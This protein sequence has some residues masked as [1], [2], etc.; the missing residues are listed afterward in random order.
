MK[1]F[2]LLFAVIALAMMSCATDDMNYHMQRYTLNFE[3]A[4]WD[5]LVDSSVNGDNLLGGAI[6]RVWHDDKSD[7]VG[8]I[9]EPYTGY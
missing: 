6:A 3:G 4:Y 2:K 7:L 1:N 5:A 9:L 8:E